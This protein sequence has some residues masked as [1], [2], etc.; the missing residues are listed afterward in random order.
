MKLKNIANLYTISK[1]NDISKE[2]A[3][4]FV[5]RC[6]ELGILEELCDGWYVAHE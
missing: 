5:S 6:V 1:Q 3:D 2:Q 4:A